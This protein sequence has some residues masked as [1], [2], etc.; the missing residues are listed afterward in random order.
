M[1]SPDAPCKH[2]YTIIILGNGEIGDWLQDLRTARVPEARLGNQTV[3]HE[4]S[5][6]R[7]RGSLR[8]RELSQNPFQELYV[9]PGNRIISWLDRRNRG[10]RRLGARYVT[11]LETP[12][13][14]SAIVVHFA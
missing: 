3:L 11:S 2:R 1:N 8:L 12:S 6:L 7:E 5:G 13:I 14:S 9:S 10:L 4:C